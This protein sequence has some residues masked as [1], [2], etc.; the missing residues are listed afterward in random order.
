MGSQDGEMEG[1]QL[2]LTEARGPEQEAGSGTVVAWSLTRLH[3]KSC[4]RARRQ[5]GRITTLD[6]LAMGHLSVVHGL[7][8]ARTIPEARASLCLPALLI[9]DLAAW[10]HKTGITGWTP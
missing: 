2:W 10:F 4:E 7:S 9:A 6:R 5:R 3:L 8:T 1:E